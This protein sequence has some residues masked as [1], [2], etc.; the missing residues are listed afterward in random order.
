MATI[1]GVVKQISGT[2]LAVDA[3]G[4]ERTLKLGDEVYL[5]ETIKTQGELSSIVIALNNGKEVTV[6]GND[7]LALNQGFIDSGS[8]D[9]VIADINS[10]QQGILRGQ[11]LEGLEATAAGGGSGAINSEGTFSQTSFTRSGNI[12]NVL[13]D[14]G[15]LGS[16]VSNNREFTTSLGA[17]TPSSD[18]T[19]PPTPTPPPA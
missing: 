11:N 7:E 17:N 18:A 15:D 1:T 12:S 4:N 2:V 5:G 14:Y 6:L 19:V 9:N 10:L 8:Q 13:A 16:V 3:N